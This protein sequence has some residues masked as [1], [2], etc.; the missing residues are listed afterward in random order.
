MVTGMNGW[1]R[2]LRHLC[3]GTLAQRRYFD[4]QTLQAIEQAVQACE[5][6]H[7]GEIR[8]V[9]EAGLSVAA[10]WRG[11]TPRDRAIDVFSQ[12]RVWDTE[13]NNGVLVYILLADRDVEIVADRGVGQPRIADEEWRV[14]CDV[15]EAHFRAGRF[16][17]GAIAG[18]E[19]VA[20]VLARHPPERRGAG[21]ELSDRPLL[22]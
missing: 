2:A 16:R 10:L 14:C 4:V 13:H 8:V 19:A 21:N 12:L 11:Q 1:L 7:A 9:V 17:E 5:A 6:R 20:D 3:T 15:M 18:V 22:I